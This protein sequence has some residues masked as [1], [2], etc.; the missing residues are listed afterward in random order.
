MK[1]RW[2]ICGGDWSKPIQ[3]EKWHPVATQRAA[4]LWIRRWVQKNRPELAG[5]TYWRFI[6][7]Q[8][9]VV[10]DFGSHVEF[11]LVEARR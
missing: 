2:T 9:R 3:G 1:V 8:Q 5:C 4:Q 11:G 7:Q 6:Q 10:I